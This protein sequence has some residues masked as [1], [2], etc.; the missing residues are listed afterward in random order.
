MQVEYKEIDNK[1]PNTVINSHIQFIIDALHRLHQEELYDVEITDYFNSL[2]KIITKIENAHLQELVLKELCSDLFS[3]LYIKRLQYQS[4]LH[5]ISLVICKL[6][7][8]SDLNTVYFHELDIIT[9]A[10]EL[11]SS[12]EDELKYAGLQI[13]LAFSNTFYFNVNV[14]IEIIQQ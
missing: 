10:I 3:K 11:F 4:T 12:S 6:I 13:F 2:N 14:F 9:P 1:T 8:I 5:A 7:S